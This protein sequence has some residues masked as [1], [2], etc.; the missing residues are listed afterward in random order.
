LPFSGTKAAVA[1]ESLD[2]LIEWLGTPERS[3]IRRAAF[4]FPE[5]L[6][7]WLFNRKHYE[8]ELMAILAS[9]QTPLN[10]DQ[11]VH[12]LFQRRQRL[13]DLL[14]L[15]RGEIRRKERLK[16]RIQKVLDSGVA[17]KSRFNG[18][19]RYAVDREPSAKVSG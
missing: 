12:Q 10:L 9:A 2:N 18:E 6:S 11:V 5:A 3:R 15:S 4:G 7:V 8:A 17:T 1:F 14:V 13:A 16:R 19:W